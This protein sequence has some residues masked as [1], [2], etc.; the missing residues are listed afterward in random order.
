M[1]TIFSSIS[2]FLSIYLSI[3]P[4][5]YISI[6]LSIF[7]SI[8]PS[9]FL[10]INLS[11]YIYICRFYSCLKMSRSSSGNIVGNLFFNIANIPCFVDEDVEVVFFLDSEHLYKS[12]CSILT[13]FSDSR[14][15]CCFCFWQIT[16][17]ISGN[18]L[19]F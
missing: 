4:Y 15:S 13:L 2:I 9:F 1:I 6:F 17:L 8:F 18:I 3:H 12:L 5:T 10:S 14:F 7:L 11:M 16:C 19:A